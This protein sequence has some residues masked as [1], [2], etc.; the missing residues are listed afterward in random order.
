MIHSDREMMAFSK[1]AYMDMNNGNVTSQLS[2]N[3][4]YIESLNGIGVSSG[5]CQNWNIVKTWDTNSVN[6]FYACIIDTGDGGATIAFRGSEGM[7]DV[8]NWV[9]DWGRADF[10]LLN[11]DQTAQQ[12][13]IIRFLSDPEVQKVLSQY[14]YVDLT[15]HSLG[16]N[17]AEYASVIWNDI[18]GL[19]NVHPGRCVSNDGPGF[20]QEFFDKYQN[21]IQHNPFTVVQYKWSTVGGQLQDIPASVTKWIK[22]KPCEGNLFSSLLYTLTRHDMSSVDFKDGMVQEGERDGTSIIGQYFSRGLDHMPSVVGDSIVNLLI[23]GGL[24]IVALLDSCLDEDG[25][26]NSLGYSVIGS[27]VLVALVN[28]ELVLSLAVVGLELLAVAIVFVAAVVLYEMVYEFVEKLID[29]IIASVSETIG[30]IRK[31]TREQID[32]FINS[33]SSAFGGLMEWIKKGINP[34]YSYATNNPY[35]KVDTYQLRNYAGRLDAVNRRVSSLDSRLDSLYGQVGL[36]DLWNLIQADL[37]T[38][39]SLRLKNC[40]GYLNDSASYFEDAENRINSNV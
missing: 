23:L 24:P 6:G 25:K 29:N 36:L 40:S 22:V 30:A 4:N 17:L 35:I 12:Q 9:N 34:G 31:W 14:D 27:L 20:S 19:E 1:I 2:H 38:S 15:G 7:T 16:G 32:A 33:V 13:E 3:S 10:K 18:P 11:S 37:L 8:G 39:Y 26:I 28:P 21:E 5:D